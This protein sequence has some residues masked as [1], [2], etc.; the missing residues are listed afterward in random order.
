MPRM[1]AAA[2]TRT[3]AELSKPPSGG[4]PSPPPPHR[5]SAAALTA[6]PGKRNQ[7]AAA[8]ALAWLSNHWSR[9]RQ[10]G[11]HT[12]SHGTAAG[13]G[14]GTAWCRTTVLARPPHTILHAVSN[15]AQDN[16][17]VRVPL[18][19][20]PMHRATEWLPNKEEKRNTVVM[21]SRLQK[22]SLHKVYGNCLTRSLPQAPRP[23][24]TTELQVFVSS[25]DDRQEERAW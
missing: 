8:A 12:P 19:R 6:S 24:Y 2:Y 10:A 15:N 21:L 11:Q 16:P 7:I 1:N 25:A 4:C 3:A 18:G 13:W 23:T 17:C 9:S 20:R 5:Q 14:S 22:E